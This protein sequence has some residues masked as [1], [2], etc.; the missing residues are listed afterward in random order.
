MT[1]KKKGRGVKF[2]MMIMGLILVTGGIIGGTFAK[3]TTQINGTDKARVAK[4]GV[5]VVAEGHLFA[6]SYGTTVDS[7][8]GNTVIAPGTS[9]S[10]SFAFTG[11]PEVAY[12]LDVVFDGS[13]TGNWDGYYPVQFKLDNGAWG[14]LEQLETAINGLSTTVHPGDAVL[15]SSVDHVVSWKWDFST[16]P[17]NDIKDTKLGNQAVAGNLEVVLNGSITATQID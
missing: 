17:A 5:G 12:Q 10:Y 15:P 6:D 9:G 11:T 2:I 1:E 8:N 13:Y 7:A 4:W 3:Y 16:S 14:T